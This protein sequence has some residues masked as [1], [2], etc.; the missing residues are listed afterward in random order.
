[1]SSYS[2]H[3]L[4]SLWAKGDL[5]AEQAVGHL[6]QNHLTLSQRQ[7]EIEQRLRRLEAARPVDPAKP[8]QA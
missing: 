3:E 1:M 5:T 6:I 2:T 4:L 7:T 8:P